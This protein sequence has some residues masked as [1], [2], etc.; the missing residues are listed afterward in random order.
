MVQNA[1]EDFEIPTLTG[2]A[3]DAVA[4]RGGHLQI[5]ASAGSGKTETVSQRIATL[6][7]EGTE[8]GE[9]VAFTFTEKAAEELKSRIR[10]RVQ[11]FAGD[12]SADKLG[13]M[14]VGTIH[15]F[16]FQ[17]LTKY[18]GKYESYDV[19]DENQLAAFVQRQSSLLKVK[20]LDPGGHQFKGI[21]RFRENLDV[22]ENEMLVTEVLPDN[23]KFSIEKFYSLMNEYRLLTFGQQIAKA[24]EA[25]QDPYVHSK[26]AKDIKHLIVDEYQDVNPAQERLIQLLAKP[27]GSAD[28]VVVGDDDQ[29]IYQWRGSTVENITTFAERYQDVTQFQLLA[30][31]RSRPPIVEIADNF[32]KSIPDRL[33]KEMSAAREHNGPALDIISDYDTEEMEVIELAQSIKKL[34]SLGF[35]YRKIAVLVRGRSAYPAIMKAF[36]QFAIP[37]QPGGRTGLFDQPDADFLG[38]CFCWLV[39][40]EWKKRFEYTRQKVSLSDL[41]ILGKSI[42]KLDSKSWKKIQKYLEDMKA[43]VGEDSR[44]I[45]LVT[46]VYDLTALL[47]VA[48]WDVKDL[49][50]ASRLGTIARFQGFI[51]DFESVQKRSRQNI[52]NEQEQ[53]GASDQKDYYYKNLASLMINV[54]VDNYL[55]FEGEDDVK[56]NSVDLMTVHASKGLEW[57]AVFLPS[58]TKK[59]FPSSRSGTSKDWLVPTELFD[60][61]RYEGSDADERRLFYVAMTRAREWLSLSAHVKVKKGNVQP[62]P[63]IQHVEAEYNEKLGYPKQWTL[64]GREI[65][66]QDL[67]ISYSEISAYLECGHSYWL[68]NLIGFPPAIIEEIGYGKAIHHLMRVIAEQTTERG[69]PL[70]PID[71]DR[72]LATDFFLPFANKA[73]ASRFRESARKLVLKYMKD[74]SGDMSRIWEVERPFELALPGVVVFGRADVILDKHEGKP[75]SLAIVDYK[76]NTEGRELDLQLQIYTIA[77]QREG[78]DVQGAFIH[79]LGSANRE[80]V[81]TSP[82][83][84]QS[85]IEVVTGAA[86][87]I[88]ER[89]FDAQPSVPKCGRCD[90]RAICRSAAA[91]P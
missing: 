91:K 38:R 77:G 89:K 8:P 31:R 5:I 65:D 4:H 57:D 19:M 7:A 10:A 49:V 54:A 86:Q 14:Y 63:Y 40:F 62:S 48:D 37:L 82:A 25:L 67:Q 24:V 46:N 9:I 18:V 87:G 3:A 2:H 56:T 64:V 60:R 69:K 17:M 1:P 73:I 27:N 53:I 12:A 16:C 33:T 83:A 85:A 59:R 76:T 55:D 41:E 75:D 43:N 50:L 42:Y 15:G 88:K 39:D 78:L 11:A 72:I 90:V 84:L 47:G 28:L 30:N 71:I 36:E 80:S 29:A 22:I 20:D 26:V 6:V 74:Y 66:E 68:R 81:D 51:A 70:K 32:A 52:E 45:S 35:E 44:K 23:L 34:V 13:N 21:S 79:D 58:L 61:F